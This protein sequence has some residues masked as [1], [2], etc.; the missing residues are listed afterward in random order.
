MPRITELLTELEAKHPNANIAGY[1]DNYGLFQYQVSASDNVPAAASLIDH[2]QGSRDVY[3]NLPSSHW[4]YT[5][6]RQGEGTD[7]PGQKYLFTKEA[8]ASAKLGSQILGRSVRLIA[9]AHGGAAPFPS[10]GLFEAAKKLNDSPTAI[11]YKTENKADKVH[12][13]EK[14]YHRALR[15]YMLSAYALLGKCVESNSG[16]GN[17]IAALLVSDKGEILSYGVN[18]KGFHHGEVNMLLNYFRSR[19]GEKTFPEKSI[20]FSTL[21]PCK[22][23]AKYI[24]ETR[25]ND[26]VVFMGQRDT[27]S[28]G[29][30]GERAPYRFK[31]LKSLTDPIMNVEVKPLFKFEEVE[32]TKPV[33]NF[34]AKTTT[35][36]TVKESVKVEA[37]FE[38]KHTALEAAMELQMTK[39]KSDSSVAEKIGEKCQTL[40]HQSSMTLAHKF[41]KERTAQKDQEDNKIKVAALAYLNDWM[42][43]VSRS[44]E[45]KPI[46]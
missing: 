17:Y 15:Y 4:L 43:N 36:Q 10:G 14:G 8:N 5:Y 34:W 19:P 41:Q 26:Y 22:Q 29:S 40:L 23:C 3:T 33:A 7:Q 20:I 35:V 2:L 45:P 28:A 11:S 24:H 21:T 39:T 12:T 37:G 30:A 27:G 31:F 38:K 1:I 16:V 18:S 6:T 13:K 46:S 25:P 32:V 42:A 44:V 9:G